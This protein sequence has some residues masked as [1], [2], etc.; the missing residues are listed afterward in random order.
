ML[1]E[2]L[3]NQRMIV[4]LMLADRMRDA[5]GKLTQAVDPYTP[6]WGLLPSTTGINKK[7]ETL[8]Q[9]RAR[10]NNIPTTDSRIPAGMNKRLRDA[11][12]KVPAQPPLGKRI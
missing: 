8:E 5:K 6:A 2:F 12:K 11:E 7:E 10:F 1:T 3:L 4:H 9:F